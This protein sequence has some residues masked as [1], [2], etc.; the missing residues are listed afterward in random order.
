MIAPLLV[1]LIWFT[2][3]MIKFEQRRLYLLSLTYSCYFIALPLGVFLPI[4][5]ID[6][7]YKY[8]KSLSYYLILA[9]FFILCLIVL[10]NLAHTVLY[11]YNKLNDWNDSYLV[12]ALTYYSFKNCALW[13][14]SI[15]FILSFTFL[16][17]F[18]W[19]QDDIE[20]DDGDKGIVI[21]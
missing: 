14:N 4:S 1:S 13:V 16:C 11:V 21:Y 15:L 6:S 8:L 17:Y 2:L 18:F 3:S 7:D 5:S 19:Y 12:G 20:Y 10:W 9:G